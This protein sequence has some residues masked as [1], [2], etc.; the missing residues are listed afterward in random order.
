MPPCM[1]DL[2][3]KPF[4]TALVDYIISGPVVAMVWEGKVKEAC[5]TC[6]HLHACAIVC[7][8]C[9]FVCVR[10]AYVHAYSKSSH[11]WMW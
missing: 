4:F 7:F 3:A 2:S 5:R 11:G 9:V 6:A 10:S 8:V 1:Q